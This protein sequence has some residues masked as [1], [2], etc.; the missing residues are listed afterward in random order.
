MLYSYELTEEPVLG[1]ACDH[2]AY[3]L[4]REFCIQI[5]V[6]GIV[7]LLDSHGQCSEVVSSVDLLGKLFQVLVEH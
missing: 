2:K 3:R 7:Q 5:N 4:R 6:Y 1:R